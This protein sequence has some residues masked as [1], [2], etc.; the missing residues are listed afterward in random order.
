MPPG[1]L[2]PAPAPPHAPTIAPKTTSSQTVV[3]TVREDRRKAALADAALRL[4]DPIDR[5]MKWDGPGRKVQ[6]RMGGA[7]IPVARLADAAW[8]QEHT[9]RKRVG[10]V[11]T[12]ASLL[13]LLPG[14]EERRDVGVAGATVRGLREGKRCGRALRVR[15]VFPQ[16]IAEAPVTQRHVARFE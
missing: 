10:H 7:G 12:D 2:P 16:R 5:T 15:D 3:K 1:C 6:D 4:I 11:V 13:L 14:A 8:V 9:R